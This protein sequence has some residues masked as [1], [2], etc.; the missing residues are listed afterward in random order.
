MAVTI[1]CKS[2]EISVIS[3]AAIATSVPVPIAIPT[4]AWARAGASLI[5]S[6]TIATIF[7][8]DCNA[9]ILAA[10]C[11]G[12]TWAKTRTMPTSWAIASAVAWLSPV[13]ITTSKPIFF[14]ALTV[15]T[16]VGL[17]ASAIPIIP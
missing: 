17:R 8:S 4:S 15:A 3:E 11:S 12:R 14:K 13:S 9:W 6:P 16:E 10:F 7:P 5:P 2:P 1:P